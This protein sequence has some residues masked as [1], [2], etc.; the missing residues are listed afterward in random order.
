MGK[1]IGSDPYSD[2]AVIDIDENNLDVDLFP[3][4]LGDSSSLETGEQVTAVGSP[5]GLEGTATFGIISQTGRM[6]S[7]E[8]Q[9]LI[10]GVIQIDAPINPGNS[11]GSLLNMEGEVIGITTA[12]QSS[13][14]SFSGIGYS[15]PS[16]LVRRVAESLIEEGEYD[17]PRLG[18]SGRNVTYEMAEEKGLERV[19]GFLVETVKP[20]TSSEGKV[21]AGDIIISIDNEEVMGIEDIL[22]Y[23]G[24]EKSP[25]EEVTLQILRNGEK[26][27]VNVELGVRSTT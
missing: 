10:P 18:I 19:R 6:L 17:H 1:V 21:Q 15:V 2:V 11:G 25:G 12:I 14:G 7:T 22:S 9:Y 8:T 24:L 3:L 13:T 16:D 20:G 4:S 27:N 23:I 5:Y 26:I